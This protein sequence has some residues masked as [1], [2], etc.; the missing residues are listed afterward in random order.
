MNI[1]IP[2]SIIFTAVLITGTAQAAEQ[3]Y[4]N[5]TPTKQQII[6]VFKPVAEQQMETAAIGSGY[7]G[8]VE[9]GQERN[10]S[11]KVHQAAGKPKASAMRMSGSKV[12]KQ[13]ETAI[14][15]QI[16]FDYKS[17]EL[18]ADA[19]HKLTPLGEAL[20]SHELKSIGFVVEGH[21]DAIG[22]DAYNKELSIQRAASVKQFLTS[23]YRVDAQRIHTIG[24]GE[25]HL[26]DP[27]NPES[28]VNRRVRI[29][30]MN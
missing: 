28:D 2:Q 16:Q 11:F 18:T 27:S 14:S 17:A 9:K 26:L 23:Q 4:G 6:N 10:I 19:K 12:K 5:M 15:M 13:T 29:V 25:T 30:A 7:E 21:T 22:G 24:K 8:D 1:H 20:A 3:N